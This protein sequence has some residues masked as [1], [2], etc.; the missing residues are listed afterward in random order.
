MWSKRVCKRSRRKERKWVNARAC[1][2]GCVG[3]LTI[4]YNGV[5]H[6][7]LCLGPF[8]VLESSPSVDLVT[9]TLMYSL[10]DPYVQSI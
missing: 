1:T 5:I 9:V 8:G 6:K 7:T 4:L 2:Y 10:F 3:K